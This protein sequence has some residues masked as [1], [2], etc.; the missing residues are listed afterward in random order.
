[1]Q[2]ISQ[3]QDYYQLDIV[4]ILKIRTE[5]SK[6][7]ENKEKTITNNP[8]FIHTYIHTHTLIHTEPLRI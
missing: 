2:R 8:L 7:L 1:M 5:K 3:L 4:N 6:N